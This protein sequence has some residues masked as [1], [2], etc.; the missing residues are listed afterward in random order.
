M[1]M[2]WSWLVGAIF[3][4]FL[5]F[6]IGLCVM[7]GTE[8][9]TAENIAFIIAGIFMIVAFVMNHYVPAIVCAAIYAYIAFMI[10][11]AVPL[12]LFVC[13][14]AIFGCIK[15][16]KHHREKQLETIK[17]EIMDQMENK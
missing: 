5:S 16:A 14:L 15:Y 8:P 9:S 3:C 2:S 4:G 7:A 12:F 13:T 6:Y 17:K 10:P 1:K 11:D